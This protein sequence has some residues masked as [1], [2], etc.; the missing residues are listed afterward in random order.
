MENH[1]YH[2]AQEKQESLYVGRKQSARRANV[3]SNIHL[4]KEGKGSGILLLTVNWI[5]HRGPIWIYE[6]MKFIRLRELQVLCFIL[7]NVLLHY[8]FFLI[9][10]IQNRNVLRKICGSLK[11]FF[12]WIVQLY[13]NQR[14]NLF[15]KSLEHTVQ[16]SI[17]HSYVLIIDMPDRLGRCYTR[18][19]FYG[20]EGLFLFFTFYSMLTWH[21][22]LA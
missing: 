4:G 14:M 5:Q 19:C 20:T 15:L 22:A 21:A 10:S 1:A 8:F 7:H 18:K 9:L 13:F 3:H 17:S 16:Q 6:Y 12:R 11:L 2:F